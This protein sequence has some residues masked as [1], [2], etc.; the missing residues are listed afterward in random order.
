ML[1]PRFNCY[2]WMRLRIS[3]KVEPKALEFVQTRE[4]EKLNLGIDL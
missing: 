4:I 3:E 1:A 2:R